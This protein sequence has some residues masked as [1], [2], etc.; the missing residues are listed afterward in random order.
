MR[1]D[2]AML[3]GLLKTANIIP[4]KTF[5]LSDMEKFRRLYM[6]SEVEISS[7]ESRCRRRKVQICL[8]A[9]TPRGFAPRRLSA[10]PY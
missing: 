3:N 7:S 5:H 10:R 6:I 8:W 2:I 4:N 9:G 1:C